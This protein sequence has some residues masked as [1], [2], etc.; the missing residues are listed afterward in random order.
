MAD[1]ASV[2]AATFA[3]GRMALL[4]TEIGSRAFVGN[5]AVLPGDYTA[6]TTLNG[7]P[8]TNPLTNQPMTLFNLNP[9][10]V[11]QSDLLITNIPELD[12][13]DYHGIE[14]TAVKRFARRWQL[15]SGFTIQRS[16]GFF[17]TGDFSDEFNDP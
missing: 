7:A 2:G 6:I 5:A 9:A 1:M 8:I 3:N 10:K 4:P 17:T 16:K 11:G 15:L 13:N 12:D 14:F